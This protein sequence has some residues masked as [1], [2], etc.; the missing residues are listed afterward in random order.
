[1]E[2]QEEKKPS[3]AYNDRE[4][5]IARQ[6]NNPLPRIGERVLIDL[7]WT[8]D[9]KGE[10]NPTIKGRILGVTET[11]FYVKAVGMPPKNV[12]HNCIKLE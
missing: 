3:E 4:R 7:F 12:L 11:H 8:P 2:E 9:S 10:P 5:E 6:I 1:M